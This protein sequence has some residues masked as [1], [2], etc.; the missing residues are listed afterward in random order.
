MGPHPGKTGRGGGTFF[1][2]GQEK[3]GAGIY[4]TDMCV[5]IWKQAPF[6]VSVLIILIV[7]KNQGVTGESRKRKQMPHNRVSLLATANTTTDGL[8]LYGN[9]VQQST[10]QN[11]S[12]L[13]PLYPLHT[14][15][16]FG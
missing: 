5:C 4:K 14:R 1:Q 16:K 10:P 2:L 11:D 12:G 13:H 7:I 8:F 6:Q 3:V 9:R 15:V